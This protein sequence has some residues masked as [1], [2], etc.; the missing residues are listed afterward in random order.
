MY[1]SIKLQKY[2]FLSELEKKV[3]VSP[4][5]RLWLR[6][7]EPD[8]MDCYYYGLWIVTSRYLC[9]YFTIFTSVGIKEVLLYFWFLKE[10]QDTRKKCKHKWLFLVSFHYVRQNSET[11]DLDSEN[12]LCRH[13]ENASLSQQNQFCVQLELLL[14]E[15]TE[16]RYHEIICADENMHQ[17]V[18]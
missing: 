13:K 14:T 2:I 1:S 6:P 18:F 10:A 8:Y 16:L 15:T 4:S 17:I 9:S 5:W 11:F 7:K 12:K 3:T